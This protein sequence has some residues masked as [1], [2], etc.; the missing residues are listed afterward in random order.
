MKINKIASC[1]L[2]NISDFSCCFEVSVQRK[3]VLENSSDISLLLRK[4]LLFVFFR[5]WAHLVMAY[6]F[7]FWAC[8]ALYKEYKIIATMRLHFLA[9]Q[10]RRP[11]QFTVSLL[12]KLLFVH[13]CLK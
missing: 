7:S 8:Y 5:F 2:Q 9:S 13:H 3:H 11:D 6:A 1:S 12:M 10:T 4:D